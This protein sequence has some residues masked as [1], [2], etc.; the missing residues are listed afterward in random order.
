MQQQPL[1][2]SDDLAPA[3]IV[4]GIEHLPSSKVAL[5]PPTKIWGE[6]RRPAKRSH[7]RVDE[8]LL[9]IP[10]TGFSKSSFSESSIH[11]G[12]IHKIFLF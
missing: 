8:C 2:D 4:Y 11:H 1:E 3:G 9:R 6:R 5:G 10:Y 12:H 7:E